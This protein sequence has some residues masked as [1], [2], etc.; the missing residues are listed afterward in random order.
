[1]HCWAGCGA[2]WHEVRTHGGTAGTSQRGVVGYWGSDWQ[3]V[4]S[5]AEGGPGLCLFRSTFSRENDTAE[6]RGLAEADPFV[7]EVGSGGSVFFGGE[8]RKA[9]GFVNQIEKNFRLEGFGQAIDSTGQVEGF[10]PMLV[11]IVG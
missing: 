5:G 2:G 4:V 7:R 3:G 10:D 11:K 1:M 6:W 9:K 8:M